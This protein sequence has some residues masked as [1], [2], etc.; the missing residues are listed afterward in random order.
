MTTIGELGSFLVGEA[1]AASPAALLCV[2]RW[3]LRP[4]TETLTDRE[5][6]GFARTRRQRALHDRFSQTG[7]AGPATR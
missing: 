1:A 6:Q 3:L 7:A 2:M 5:H 4:G